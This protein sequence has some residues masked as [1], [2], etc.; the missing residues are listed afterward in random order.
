ML[1]QSAVGKSESPA[2]HAHAVANLDALFRSATM[3]G[4]AIARATNIKA[5]HRFF[6]L[7]E[8]NGRH[9][10]AKLTVKEVAQRYRPDCSTQSR[11]WS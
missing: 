2:A 7:I 6:A 3:D 11:L 10:L 5:I 1:S 9:L 8:H 4:R